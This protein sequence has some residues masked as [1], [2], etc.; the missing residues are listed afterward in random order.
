MQ[1]ETRF[2]A[3][4]L[5]GDNPK[6]PYTM[7]HK[8]TGLIILTFVVSTAVSIKWARWSCLT[9]WERSTLKGPLKNLGWH[10]QVHILFVEQYTLCIEFQLKT[11]VNSSDVH[12]YK[13]LYTHAKS[14]I[15]PSTNTHGHSKGTVIHSY[16][17]TW[18]GLW[19]TKCAHR[20]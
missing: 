2:D 13:Y 14:Y 15:C 4:L 20:L 8:Y 16:L 10:H 1:T 6:N 17:M 9:V 18:S 19:I 12:T 7:I 3:F 11:W 5:W